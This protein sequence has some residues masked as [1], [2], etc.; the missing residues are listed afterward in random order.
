MKQPQQPRVVAVEE[1]ED[2]GCRMKDV[3]E[4]VGRIVTIESMINE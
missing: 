4:E 3:V 1:V 2:V